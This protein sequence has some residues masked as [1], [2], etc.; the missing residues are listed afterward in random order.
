M[1]SYDPLLNLLARIQQFTAMYELSL[2]L[3][4][5]H[6][7]SP[8]SSTVQRP[9]V[10]VDP[11]R[12]VEEYGDYLYRYARSRVY[13]D[14]AA[15]DVVQETFLAA[16][17][18]LDSFDGKADV[19]Y[20]L[21][22]ILRNKTVDF[23]RKRVRETPVEELR[24]YD[25]EPNWSRR[26]MGTPGG[27]TDPWNFDPSSV[28]EDRDFWNVFQECLEDVKSPLREVYVLKEIDNVS[29]EQI[30]EAFAITPNNVWVMVH[31][32]RKQL[33]RLLNERWERP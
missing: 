32:A 25:E 4:A 19:K 6:A 1:N 2:P 14:A 12:W 27:R 24:D 5:A 30:C 10:M 9:S 16:L 21:R 18:G 17:K 31:R 23:I 3:S 11:E 7:V 33:K 26:W 20:W 15:Q 13:D 8:P 29:T 22:G 28:H